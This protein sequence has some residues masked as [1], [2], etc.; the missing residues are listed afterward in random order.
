M[1]RIGLGYDI[2]KLTQGRDLI[3][4][5]VKITHEKGLLGHSDADVLV[6]AI[7]DAMLGALAMAD[8]G[9]LFPDT[10]PFYKGADSIVLLKK[11]YEM[12]SRNPDISTLSELQAKTPDSVV[13]IMH[14]EKNEKI[15]LNKEF[16]LALGDW[17]YNF[18]AGL[19][20]EGE[21]PIESARRE[22]KEET[23]L[24][25]LTVNDILPLSYSAIGFANETNL[26]IVGVANGTFS[27]SS[28]T[29]E[30]IKAG[31]YTKDE[32]KKLLKTELFAARTQSYC[33]LWSK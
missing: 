4:G 33:Y 5:G 24:D 15:L 27:K 22:L 6:H 23:G 13:L 8:I 10:D 1:Y 3:I 18:P 14:D 11:V 28:S 32:V 19:I 25:L 16:R 7:I 20:D 9:T 31:W 17:V 29:V 30:E 26:C 21:E 2:H 12:I